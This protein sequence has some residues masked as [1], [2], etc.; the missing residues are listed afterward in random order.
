V[1]AGTIS[2]LRG[3]IR[4]RRYVVS[5]HAAEE[6]DD[7]GLSVF[8]LESVVLTGDIVER[9]RD[10]ETREQKY[11]IRG[12]TLSGAAA[13]VVAKFGPTGR[14]VLITIYLE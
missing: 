6:M 4:A 8:D 9:Q 12:R 7:D 14:A 10:R 2:R 5:S 13:S 3:L 1:A 11:I